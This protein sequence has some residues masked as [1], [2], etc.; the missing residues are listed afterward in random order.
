MPTI[1]GV[2][3]Y[4]KGKLFS[5]FPRESLEA[6]QGSVDFLNNRDRNLRGELVYEVVSFTLNLH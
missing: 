1:F 5:I 4:Y 3:T 2:A 6:A